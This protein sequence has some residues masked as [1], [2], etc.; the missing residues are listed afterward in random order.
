MLLAFSPRSRQR[1]QGN[2]LVS[3]DGMIALKVVNLESAI[4]FFAPLSRS[5]GF[6]TL[7]LT[8]GGAG[9]LSTDIKARRF[10]VYCVDQYH[11]VGD[12]VG[13]FSVTDQIGMGDAIYDWS[14]EFG[15]MDPDSG[16]GSWLTVTRVPGDE[17]EMTVVTATELDSVS[18]VAVTSIVEKCSPLI[19]SASLSTDN[20][21]PHLFETLG[22]D[23]TIP[24]CG[25]FSSP[26]WLEIEV[27]REII[28]ATQHVASVDMDLGTPAV[29]RYLDTSSLGGQSLG[30]AWDGR[31]QVTLPLADHPDLFTQ[32]HTPFHRAMPEIRDGDPVPPPFYTVAV[33]LWNSG[34]TE[35]LEEFSQ[36]VFIPQVVAVYWQPEAVT[37]FRTPMLHRF[38]DGDST[39]VYPGYYGDTQI[40]FPK[41]LEQANKF[42]PKDVNLRLVIALIEEPCL[43]SYY[44]KRVLVK[45]DE[46]VRVDAKKQE[47]MVLGETGTIPRNERAGLMIDCYAGSFLG[48][49]RNTY[50]DFAKGLSKSQVL[51]YQEMFCITN[52]PN[53]LILAMGHNIAHETG[54]S[55][56]LVHGSYMVDG[57]G[58]HNPEEDENLMMNRTTKSFQRL[59]DTPTTWKELNLN[60]LKFILPTH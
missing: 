37:A 58:Y 18:R 40:L 9:G 7:S 36:A 5:G 15:D 4:E 42:M 8:G 56:G 53:T 3:P 39:V 34:K 59:W 22:I 21:S 6:Q 28:G 32:G 60:Y 10:G 55:L 23:V 27:V 16:M 20:F 24:G 43:R 26:G 46:V 52:A 14:S 2:A 35:V 30:Y 38:P 57:E 44:V 31:A 29:D 13:A 1:L 19:F 51:Q 50:E 41:L 17:E 25:H 47:Y 33:R 49:W 12:A 48:S 45:P 11:G 54:H